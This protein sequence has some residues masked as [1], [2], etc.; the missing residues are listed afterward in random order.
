MGGNGKKKT[1]VPNTYVSRRRFRSHQKWRKGER[2][3]GVK[4]CSITR[5]KREAGEKERKKKAGLGLEKLRRKSGKKKT[6]ASVASKSEREKESEAAYRNIGR[7]KEQGKGIIIENDGGK[8]R[9]QNRPGLQ[10]KKKKK[11]GK[12]YVGED[13]TNDTGYTEGNQGRGFP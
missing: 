13:G 2:S 5:G 11:W 1:A 3:G 7:A 6:K 9:D 12:T 10:K 8:P 4:K